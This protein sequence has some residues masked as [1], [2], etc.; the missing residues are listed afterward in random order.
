MIAVRKHLARQYQFTIPQKLNLPISVEH[1][2]L[3]I[4]RVTEPIAL[5]KSPQFGQLQTPIP[6]G[7]LRTGDALS[8][9]GPKPIT[10]TV[11]IARHA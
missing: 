8:G 9:G 5:R 4:T 7:L 11:D 10:S 2:K 6:Q 1:S 3:D